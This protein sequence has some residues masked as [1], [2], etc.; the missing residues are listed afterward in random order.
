[1]TTLLREL[2]VVVVIAGFVFAMPLVSSGILTVYSGA[3]VDA[4]SIQTIV[5]SF[6]TALRGV[7]GNAPG[8]LATGFREINWDGGGTATTVSP[9][10]FGGFR[11]NRGAFFTTGGTGLYKLPPAGLGTTCNNNPTYGI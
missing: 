6:R 8:P 3:G 9:T 1:M 7:N 11:D 10:P 5:D 4:T 2:M